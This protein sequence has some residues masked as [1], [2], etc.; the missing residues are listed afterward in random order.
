MQ[1][2]G[3]TFI[4]DFTLL[5]EAREEQR[6]LRN[7]QLQRLLSSSS[8]SSLG[9]GGSSSSLVGRTSIFA[10]AA[11]HHS[12]PSYTI[13][14][15]TNNNYHTL[16]L[17][18]GGSS[19]SNNSNSGG[20]TRRTFL[21]DL[22][23]DIHLKSLERIA[24][25]SPQDVHAQHVF[26]SELSQYYPDAV[27]MRFEQYPSYAIDERI[28]LLYLHALVRSGQQDKFGMT[29]FIERL[30]QSSSGA[31][32]GGGISSFT[33]D[34][35][36]EL[37][38]EKYKKGEMANRAGRILESSA[39]GAM[40][41]MGSSAGGGGMMM[42][43]GGIGSG[44][45]GGGS[46]PL[47][48]IRGSSPNAPLFVQSYNPVKTREMLF[49]LTR[50]VLI[51]FVVVSAL[52][53]V[54]TEQGLGRGGMGGAMGNGK[55]IQESEGSAVRFDDVKGV[56]EAKAEL[57]EIVLYLKDPDRFT[58]LG[59]KLPRGLLLTGEVLWNMYCCYR[60]RRQKMSYPGYVTCQKL[61]QQYLIL[62][63]ILPYYYRTT[64]NW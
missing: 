16:L 15:S 12:L 39:A 59:G 24:N 4:Q 48:G 22:R 60:E 18:G 8:S 20:C 14:A 26:L 19:L 49:A 28:A 9:R 58:R 29:K 2:I 33:I 54:F 5:R 62:T 46:F 41:M 3:I 51:A 45:G 38:N 53:V 6:K 55:H 40:T 11:F 25:A 36:H 13:T 1:H 57:E 61:T 43:G 52:T 34:K 64:R 30:Q 56:T 50:Q 7:Q 42:A 47:G 31:G 32:G 17:G 37:S 27:V 35:L 63:H 23:R 10:N 21:T 44:G